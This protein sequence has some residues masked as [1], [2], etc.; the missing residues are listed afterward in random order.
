MKVILAAAICIL[1]VL[2]NVGRAQSNEDLS[3]GVIWE[4]EPYMVVD[5]ANPQHIVVAW[6]G[7]VPLAA[8]CIKTITTFNGGLTWS[9]PAV[10]PHQSPTYTSAD[11]SMAFDHAG[12][13][14]T[15]YIDSRK[16]P[17]SGAV[18]IVKSTDGGLTWGTASQVISGF[19]DGSKYPLD[20]PWLAVASTGGVDTIYVTS[21][22]APWVAPPNRP[23]FVKS[24]DGGL[25][26]T[27]W[28]NIDST[29]YLVGNVIQ[30]PMAAPA[31]D[32]AGRFHCIYPAYL[33]SES[34]YPRYIMATNG[35]ANSFSYNV[36]ETI[37]MSGGTMDT[38]AKAGGK[39]I[40][41]PAHNGHFAF[42]HVENSYG[43]IDV[44]SIETTDSGVTWSS[45]LRVNDDVIGNGKM[46]DMAW[47]NFDESGNLVTAWR[48]RRNAPGTGYEQPTEIWGAIKWY[49]SSAFSANFKI[50]DTAAPYDSIYLFGA[51]NDFMN[52][53]MAQ[54]TLSAVWGDVRT[55][56][57]NIW[58]SR[59]AM[60]TGVTT[61][62]KNI[63]SEQ[64]P[65]VNIYPN[66]GSQY[67]TIEGKGITNI[68]LTDIMGKTVLTK[69][70]D[71]TRSVLDVSGI[72]AGEYVAVISTQDGMVTRK[73][74]IR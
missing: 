60:R 32:S 74:E 18:Y 52:V 51:G 11:V 39:F 7:S 30:A 37:T 14:F 4:S 42:V 70:L 20:R 41:D 34:I 9:S 8:L 72:T 58:F 69:K 36:A 43:D 17:D 29:G 44:F 16:S 24:S 57:L 46:Q 1:C 59:R 25:T 56:T 73:V 23:Y 27:A 6:M 15:T 47:A 48:D 21:K 31:I 33:A 26:W 50:S 54:D 66:P 10:I 3:G 38:L 61:M 40:C 53:A 2:P 55:G 64:L 35:P 19:A 65:D 68:V 13:L 62:V 45:P 67:L 28:R 5:P 71:G 12:N 22:P 49:D 63:V